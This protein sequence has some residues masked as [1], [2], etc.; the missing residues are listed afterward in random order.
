MS[1]LALELIAKAKREKA[2]VLDLGKCGLREL[3][4][5]LFELVWLEELYLCNQYWDYEARKWVESGNEGAAN[6]LTSLE[7]IDLLLNLRVLFSGGDDEY[8]YWQIKDISVIQ[9]LIKLIKLNLGYNNIDD[10]KA[11]QHLTNLET[12]NLSNNKLEDIYDLQHLKAL[13]N[14]NISSNKIEFISVLIGLVN[15]QVLDISSNSINGISVIKHLTNLHSLNLS[16][17]FIKNI[18]VI[19]YLVNLQALNL[20]YN[21]T[22]NISAIFNLTNL[23]SLQ[24]SS[25]NIN[26]ISVLQNLVNLQS[27][28]LSSNNISD[29]SVLQ[30]LVNLQNLHL[31]SNSISDISA[32]QNLSNLQVLDLSSNEISDIS[33]L[34]NLINLQI[35]D[36]SSNKISDIIVFQGLLELCELDINNNIIT[37]ISSIQHL[38]QKGLSFTWGDWGE[39]KVNLKDNPIITPPPEIIKQGNQAI[40]NYFEELERQG[41]GYL[42][43]AKMLILGEGG[44][45]KTTLVKKLVDSNSEMPKEEETTKGIDISKLQFTTPEGNN[46]TIN[47]WDFGGQEIYHSTHQ[48]FLTKRSLYILVDDTRKDDRSVNN[49]V[50]RYWLQTVEL[51]GGG[52][53]LLIVQNEKGGR[54]KDI[55]LSSMQV[56]FRFIKDKYPTNLLTGKG[57]AEVKQAIQFYIHQLP[58]IGQTLP[59]QWV[60]IRNELSELAK[61]TPYIS[62]SKYC[63][64]CAK[65]SIT[66]RSRALDLSKYL[67][68]LGT[69]LH[70]QDDPL[71]NKT[72]VLQNEWVTNAV[73]NIIDNEGVKARFGRFH[74]SEVSNIWEEDIYTGMHDELIAL[75]VNFE[76]CY[77]VEG[78]KGQYLIPQLLPVSRPKDYIWEKE[79]N[80][81]L[82][83]QYEFMPKG[84][85]S[86]FIIRM[87]RYI[88]NIE[89]VWK[90][91][92]N[93]ERE[94]T[95]AEITETYARNE[96]TIRIK[97]NHKK[98]LMTIVA[99]EIDKI[100]SLYEG[101][102]VDKMIP[103]NCT[104]CQNLLEP[105]F[106]EFDNL[107][108]RY[109]NLKETVECEK[110]PYESVSVSSLMDDVFIT[111]Q[112]IKPHST[113]VKNKIN[114]QSENVQIQSQIDV[115]K[116]NSFKTVVIQNAIAIGKK[117]WFER[118]IGSLVLS[119]LGS[120]IG[121][122]F[123]GWDFLD[124]FLIVSL[125]FTSLLF[126]LGNPTRRLYNASI[127]FFLTANS[128][129]I[130]LFSRS[131]IRFNH[132][133]GNIY[134]DLESS[135]EFNIVIVVTLILL[136]FI[137][138]LALVQTNISIETED[139]SIIKNKIETKV[140]FDLV[141]SKKIFDAN[142]KNTKT[143][144][145]GLKEA[146][147]FE[148]KD[149]F[150]LA[151][152]VYEGLIQKND[153]LIQAWQGLERCYREAGS[154]RKAYDALERVNKLEKS[155]DFAFNITLSP[156]V[157]KL[158]LSGLTFFE[159]NLSWE[160]TSKVNILL[161]RNGFGK[162]QLIRLVAALLS[163][164]IDI[165]PPYFSKSTEYNLLIIELDIPQQL[166][167][168]I[169]VKRSGLEETIGRVPLLAIPDLRSIDRSKKNLSLADIGDKNIFTQSINSFLYQTPFEST[170]QTLLYGL[171]IEYLD[172]G[173]FESPKFNIIQKVM[174]ELT[175]QYF[176]FHSVKRVGATDFQLFV[177]T[178]LDHHAPVIIQ[179]ASQG[180][181]SILCIIGLI[182][183]FL[184][185]IAE[186]N[187]QK[188]TVT[189]Q[190]A[191]V[192]ID[193]IDAHLHPIWQQKI[194]GL[195]RNT[196]PN[197]QFILTAHN[198]LVVSGCFEGEVSVLREGHK[199]HRFSL[200]QFKNINFIGK[201]IHDI[202]D[203]V[204]DLEDVDDDE[205][206][207]HYLTKL[208]TLEDRFIDERINEL[209]NKTGVPNEEDEKELQELYRLN[210]IKLI[211][212]DNEL[213]NPQDKI[214]KLEAKIR[215][216][217]RLLNKSKN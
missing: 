93:L 47:L 143:I 115:E 171:C 12:L 74:K 58:H 155:F 128:G 13:Y 191:I 215:Q 118:I 132:Q 102:Q 113:H 166:P 34:Q 137:Y 22:T 31:S 192:I 144:I 55:D 49:E 64:L 82:R 151:I 139:S 110:K 133:T 209:E 76:L 161:G 20:G 138:L 124:I 145:N 61:T 41:E 100:N 85:L 42:Y 158:N 205:T 122:Q 70:F 188:K 56:Q 103:C 208:T 40:L 107:R 206:Y 23:Q 185:E 116:P 216:L 37:D 127:V 99:E 183:D 36:L 129:L 54:S 211:K 207:L 92:V 62:L 87:H 154:L 184:Y 25:N 210:Q 44:V 194:I 90:K 201:K 147:T 26:D 11:I 190:R 125:L 109:I 182:Y 176:N 172:N 140:K 146:K 81:Q 163:S 136:C 173:S 39:Y 43:E 89:K 212:Q 2:K 60:T 38:A 148:Q 35:L 160:F 72:I 48:F 195:L 19:Q 121:S 167:N 45:G 204:F 30:N 14:L 213:N 27:L 10:I 153:Y 186:F 32:L 149:Q 16:S 119:F 91:G 198:P 51:F 179:N 5:E 63:E 112:I 156:I 217:E 50:F 131:I 197:V 193:E 152:D 175:G 114:I 196:F 199:S 123:F 18:S 33:V 53:P 181:L 214:Q 135:Q 96:I 28:H 79:Q 88:S 104:T 57:L 3:P 117:W 164:S 108:D 21:S 141:E 187:Q 120:I 15:I 73:Y 84:L 83:Y 69:F 169:K 170:I 180:T 174:N 66:E 46:F 94:N 111:Q 67:N 1:E 101:I 106:F 97:G 162:S 95:F 17:N 202:Y 75:M 4:K 142:S 65:H 165:I 77:E 126:Y 178:D 8:G 59:K 157:S 134:L 52:S 105:H 98:E 9:S 150:N 203:H 71:L 68:D 80:L 200:Y 177:T 24:L 189:N 6:L 159:K 130:F 86:R 7:G 168:K 29:I 78:Q